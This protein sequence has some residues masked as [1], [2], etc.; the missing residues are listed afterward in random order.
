MLLSTDQNTGSLQ[1][2]KNR[3]IY[4]SDPLLYWIA[5]EKAGVT[6]P[7]DSSQKLAELVANEFL[8]RT[9]KRFGYISSKDGEIDFYKSKNWALEIKW[10]PVAKDISKLYHSQILPWKKVWTQGNFLLEIPPG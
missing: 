6:P 8:F 1:T 4:F 10:S 3:K 9:Q 7:K 5:L 2:R